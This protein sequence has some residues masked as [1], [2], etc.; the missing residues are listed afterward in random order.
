MELY[1]TE[2]GLIVLFLGERGSDGAMAYLPKAGWKFQER[3][4]DTWE[5]LHQTVYRDARA[6]RWPPEALEESGIPLPSIER[7]PARGGR[8]EHLGAE[9]PFAALPPGFLSKLKAW[10]KGHDRLFLILH[11]DTYETNHGDGKSVDLETVW[12]EEEGARR[13]LAAL[14]RDK[15]EFRRFTLRGVPV[16]L[17]ED[18]GKATAELGVGPDEHYALAG[19]FTLL[20]NEKTLRALEAEIGSRLNSGEGHWMLAAWHAAEADPGLDE[21]LDVPKDPLLEEIEPKYR[22][23]GLFLVSFFQSQLLRSGSYFST[24]KTA[25]DNAAKGWGKLDDLLKRHL[26]PDDL[27]VPLRFLPYM[28]RF[29]DANR[30]V[31]VYR[32][33]A[34]ARTVRDCLQKHID[35]LERRQGSGSKSS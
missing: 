10:A 29:V 12:W 35:E 24:L 16:R 27:A 26:K 21:E 4:G 18:A 5:S 7:L 3:G 9:V 22:Q 8:T 33:G 2:S 32:E 23:H 14:E 6:M 25:K 34:A 1:K 31:V 17:D 15:N 20:I 28:K 11:E 19:M 13:H 30:D